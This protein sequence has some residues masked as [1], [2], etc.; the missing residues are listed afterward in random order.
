MG[1]RPSLFPFYTLSMKV[2]LC[3]V[4]TNH[5]PQ[6]TNHKPQ[7]TNH[8]P[9]T[10]NHKPQ[11]TNHK[12]RL[13][14]KWG[15]TLSELLVSLAV[16]GL[17][18]GLTVPSIVAS[19]SKSKNKI[20]QKETI[21]VLATIINTGV[22]DGSLSEISNYDIQSTSSPLVQYFTTRLNATPCPKG[23]T[24]FP[25][26][27]NFMNEG[28]TSVRNNH[29]ARWVFSNG[30]KVALNFWWLNAIMGSTTLPTLSILIDSK[31]EG[32]NQWS[33]VNGDQ[34]SIICNLSETTITGDTLPGSGFGYTVQAPMKSGFC[35]PI[36]YED[37]FNQYNELYK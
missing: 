12:P 17:I 3:H 36:N 16:L 5:K 9:Q 19:V 35:G 6:T 4:Q 18:A 8:K 25:C 20:L 29:S 1:D 37:S 24:T 22:L 27:F 26:D 11:T 28:L 15:F 30:V 31:P 21:Q 23:N 2:L 34:I 7:T 32:T 13:A 14:F 10:T 33:V